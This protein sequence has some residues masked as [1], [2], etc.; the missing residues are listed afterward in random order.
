[1]LHGGVEQ[2]ADALRM[3]GRNGERLAQPERVKVEQ[4]VRRK[5]VDLVHRQKDGLF[6]AAELVCDLVVGRGQ[7][8]APVDEQND[9]LR[10]FDGDVCLAQDL[11]PHGILRAQFDAARVDDGEFFAAPLGVGIQPVARDARA[12]LGDGEPP[13]DDLIEEGALP[14]IGA[15]HDGDEWIHESSVRNST[16]YFFS[17]YKIRPEK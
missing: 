3:L 1:M 10:R 4:F 13:P 7:L 8:F 14:H 5:V 12:V 17:L 9:D 11:A 6:A 16:G 2:I 15:P